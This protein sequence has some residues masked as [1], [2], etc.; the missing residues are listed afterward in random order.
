MIIRKCVQSDLPALK[1]ILQ[2]WVKDELEIEERLS[3]IATMCD[4][5][6]I[7]ENNGQIVGMIGFQPLCE[8]VRKF[9]VDPS[10]SLEIISAFV[11]KDQRGKGIGT[12]LVK[13]V[14]NEAKQLGY[15]EVIAWSG[16]RYR[17]TGWSF[18]NSV[19]GMKKVGSVG[20]QE[21]PVWRKDL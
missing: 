14:E 18:W 17:D 9:V 6:F 12:A 16:P 20:S 1:R 15:S 19:S 4:N 5:F 8:E 21:Y 7:A 3:E 2:D 10:Q 13:S 11:N